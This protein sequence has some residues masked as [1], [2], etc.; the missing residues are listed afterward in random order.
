MTEQEKIIVGA[1][2]GYSTSCICHL[3]NQFFYIMKP[4]YF[5]TIPL[6]RERQL[7][8]SDLDFPI[9]I[10][11]G[12][13]DAYGSVGADKIIRANQYYESGESQLFV[14]DNSGHNTM[15]DNP[16]YL[17]EVMI[18][19]FTGTKKNYWEEHTREDFIPKRPLTVSKQERIEIE[20]RKSGRPVSINEGSNRSANH[21]DMEPLLPPVSKVSPANQLL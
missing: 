21:S 20:A 13:R 7:G 15:W 1:H 4:G 5:A 9:G 10:A 18:G 8:N 2:Q 12:D 14:I 17:V 6:T 11:F 19:F 16:E 3:E